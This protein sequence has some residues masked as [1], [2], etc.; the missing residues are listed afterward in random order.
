M[1]GALGLTMVNVVLASSATSRLTVPLWEYVVQPSLPT[2][3]AESEWSLR[4]SA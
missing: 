1:A 2:P 3:T 4:R